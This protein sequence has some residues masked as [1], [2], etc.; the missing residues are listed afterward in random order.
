AFRPAWGKLGE[1][2]K[3]LS[4]NVRWKAFSATFPPHILETVTK[5]ILKTNYVSIHV[6]SNRPN[7]IY[8]THQVFESIDDARNYECFIHGP[9]FDFDKQPHVLIFV[10]NKDHTNL[11]ARHLDSLLPP[12]Y[13]DRGVVRHYHSGMSERYLRQTHEEFVKEDGLCRILISTSGQSVGVD[14]PNVKIVCTAGL[15][16][17]MVDCLQRGGRAA[18]SSGQTALFVVFFE[19]NMLQINEK[20][21]TGDVQDPDRPR[22][23]LT[24]KPKRLER[25]PLSG[26]RL[27]Q[28]TGCLRKFFA[29]YLN[30][31]SPEAMQFTT[32]FCCDRHDDGFSLEAELP[33]FL[34]CGAV[35]ESATEGRSVQNRYRPKYERPALDRL[36]IDWVE[37]MAEED[38][39][40]RAPYDILSHMQRDKIQRVAFKNISSPSR[41]REILNETEEWE[42]EWASQIY[43]IIRDYEP[44]RTRKPVTKKK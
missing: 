2:K 14:F 26:V 6:T 23:K 27:V 3:I 13:R 17:T 32:Q 21:F 33:G 35:E 7:T 16:A 8:A 28:T 9:V 44:V 5:T 38:K 18:R 10:D 20:E 31:K 37:R 43:Q 29:D 40:L 1:L 24:A 30:D 36:L 11:I 22:E 15:P 34:Y 25:A 42:A 19:K 39:T 41:I 12:D 4:N